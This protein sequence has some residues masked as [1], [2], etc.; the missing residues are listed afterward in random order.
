MEVLPEAHGCS[1]KQHERLENL[2]KKKATEN[3]QRRSVRF[4]S[5]S[6]SSSLTR[7]PLSPCPPFL[8]YPKKGAVFPPLTTLPTEY[9]YLGFPCTYLTTLYNNRARPRVRAGSHAL[10]TVCSRER[11]SSR[12]PPPPNRA[13]TGMRQNWVLVGE[14][15]SKFRFL[16]HRF[17]LRLGMFVVAVP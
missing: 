15:R 7:N 17:V 8:L 11:F 13:S 2:Q 14:N 6:T 5:D 10:Y 9:I 4:R 12:H 3:E 16:A 1:S